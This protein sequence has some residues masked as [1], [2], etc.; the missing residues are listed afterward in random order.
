M[1]PQH[2]TKAKGFSWAYLDGL[3]MLW[4]FLRHDA[5]V[6]Q[7]LSEYK[8]DQQWKWKMQENSRLCS[9]AAFSRKLEN[10]ILLDSLRKWEGKTWS[11]LEIFLSSFL[12]Q[13]EKFFSSWEA[14]R[15]WIEK[16]YV[17][18]FLNIIAFHKWKCRLQFC[19]PQID[20]LSVYN[21]MS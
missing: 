10:K 16:I 12:W 1:L 5:N 15:T 11:F 4:N 3:F 7:L 2:E 21:I 9:C 17:R 14:M 13:S 18:I 6:L 8:S 20:E 19:N